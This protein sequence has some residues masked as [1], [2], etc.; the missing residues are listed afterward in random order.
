MLISTMFGGIGLVMFGLWGAFECSTSWVGHGS[1]LCGGVFV[2]L[3]PVGYVAGLAL[4]WL[5]RTLTRA[6]TGGSANPN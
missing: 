5:L 3:A 6:V 2:L 1:L 4:F